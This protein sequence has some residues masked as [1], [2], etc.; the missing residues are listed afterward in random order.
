MI[1]EDRLEQQCLG[2]FREGG[3]DTVFGPDLAHSDFTFQPR[4]QNSIA[5]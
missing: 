1:T 3:W 5:P 4:R 2:W